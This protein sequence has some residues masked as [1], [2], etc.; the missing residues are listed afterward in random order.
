MQRILNYL[1]VNY[2]YLAFIFVISYLTVVSGRLNVGQKLSQVFL[3]D[4]PISVFISAIIIMFLIRLVIGRLGKSNG[5][6]ALSFSYL[7][8]Y[9]LLGFLA[10]LALSNVFGLFI[11]VLF[12]TIERNFNLQTLLSRNIGVAIN[13][14][15]F[16]SIYLAYW[17]L[18]ENLLYREKLSAYDKSLAANKIQQLKAQLNPH[19]LFNNLNTL[20]QLIEEDQSK[21]S[22]YLHNFAELYRYSLVNAEKELV[23]IEDEI[24]LV[25]NYFKLVE[26]KYD[27]YHLVIRRES[28]HR[29]LF[30]P[31]LALQLLVENAVEHNHATTKEPVNIH[32]TIDDKVVV[33]NNLKPSKKKRSNGVALKNLSTQF[34]L[35]AHQ[36]IIVEHTEE[37]F[38]VSLPLI[39]D[40]ACV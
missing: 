37:M 7:L 9:F 22:N 30:L 5:V 40:K 11:S 6:E 34:L 28:H 13:Y 35:L 33:S 15:L 21:A 17:S 32:I 4:G 39:T 3:P 14:I 2:Q 12:D 31:P 36:D 26:E 10:Y 1:R 27:G 16:G 8:K 24:T 19:F 18:S 20:D 25:E 29:Q 38:K 23:S